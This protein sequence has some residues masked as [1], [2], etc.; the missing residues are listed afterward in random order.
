MEFRIKEKVHPNIPN[1]AGKDF[2]TA[3]NFSGLMERELGKFVK[4]IVL[5]GST[6]RN[7]S[8]GFG[9]R[10]IDILVIIDDLVCVMSNEVIEAYR[11]IAERCASRVSHRLH[12]TTLK[13]TSFWDYVRTSDPLLINM[14]R[15][16]VPL[17]DSGFFQA[18]QE[19]LFQGRMRPTKES[20]WIYFARA[21]ATLNN[22]DGHILQAVMDLYWAVVDSAH[23]AI[24]KLGEVPPTPAHIAGLID[25]L[26][27]KTGRLNKKYA[28]C[29]DKFYRLQ[30]RIAHREIQKIKGT[31]FDSFREEAQDFVRT[32]QAVVEDRK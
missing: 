7:E 14:L 17:Y 32:M 3:K 27:V 6:A 10:D 30:K 22:A 11:I 20:I 16:G 21:P 8:S 2:E 18:M 13:T 31:E 26:L 1:Y 9:E 25:R 23:A 4:A 24:M 12:I 28:D 15:D 29:M 5:F 19:L